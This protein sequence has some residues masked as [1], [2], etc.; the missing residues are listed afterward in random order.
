MAR[1]AGVKRRLAMRATLPS[2]ERA[3]RGAVLA[4]VLAKIR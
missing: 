4:A 3:R 2:S 1:A